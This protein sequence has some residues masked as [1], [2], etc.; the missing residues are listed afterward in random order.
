[1]YVDSVQRTDRVTAQRIVNEIVRWGVSPAAA[2]RI[3][4]DLLERAPGAIAAAR[5]ETGGVPGD[6]V[7]TIERRLAQL[8]AAA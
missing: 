2:D 7:A 4:G 5:E 6:L 8:R 1:M 3:V